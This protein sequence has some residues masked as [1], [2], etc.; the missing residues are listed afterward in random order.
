[1]KVRCQLGMAVIMKALNGG[2]LDHVVHALD[3]TVGL[4]MLNLGEPVF[5]VVLIADPVEDMVEGVLVVR[6]VGEPDAIIGEHGVDGI[7]HGSDQVAQEL[8]GDHLAS[9]QV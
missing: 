3:L 6:Q 9:L 2:L 7:R 1:M 4:G 8:G 5:D